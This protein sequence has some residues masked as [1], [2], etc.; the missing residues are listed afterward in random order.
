MTRSHGWREVLAPRQ[1]GSREAVKYEMICSGF[2]SSLFQKYF[3]SDLW[4]CRQLSLTESNELRY[5]HSSERSPKW[6]SVHTAVDQTRAA[7]GNILLI[8]GSSSNLDVFLIR[9]LRCVSVR[10]KVQH[11][12]LIHKLWD[13]L[14]LQVMN[15]DLEVPG[16]LAGCPTNRAECF[17]TF[18]TSVSRDMNRRLMKLGRSN[19]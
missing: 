9:S 18:S 6:S 14:P 1:P 10:E 17:K 7:P 12:P 8:K 2:R 5:Q 11:S 3:F 19:M 13:T 15:F 16:W 4:N